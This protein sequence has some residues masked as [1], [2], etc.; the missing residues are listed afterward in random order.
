MAAGPIGSVW[1]TGSWSDTAWEENTWADAV[2]AVISD[3]DEVMVL[4]APN[5]IACSVL[6]GSGTSVRVVNQ[7]AIQIHVLITGGTPIR[8]TI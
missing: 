3:G 1:A 4:I 7:S 2:A 6:I 5:G 8:V